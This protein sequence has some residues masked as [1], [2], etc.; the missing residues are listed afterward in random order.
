[1]GKNR[2]VYILF[3]ALGVYLL[4]LYD[5]YV[6]FVVFCLLLF[7]PLLSLLCLLFW[8]LQVK[9]T[10]SI[11]EKV[12]NKNESCEFRL[13]LKNNSIFPILNGMIRIQYRLNPHGTEERKNSSF[14][15]DSREK[16]QIVQKIPCPHCGMVTVSVE[17]IK[18]YDYFRLF[19]VR[20]PVNI[21]ETALIFPV[22]SEQDKQQVEERVQKNIA[23]DVYGE[24]NP[25]VKDI[26]EYRQG[27]SL[28]RI[29]WKLSSKQQQLMVKE[30]SG[31]QYQKER[32]SFSLLYEGET[33]DFE[34]YDRKVE[35]LANTCFSM[36]MQQRP[37]E[38]VWYHP[39][40]Q[41]FETMEIEKMEDIDFLL[42]NVMRAGVAKKAENDEEQL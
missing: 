37:H 33:F 3:L 22:Y 35:E 20:I 13:K 16:K 14:L 6:S 32:I 42:A 12:V 17:K 36:L 24:T 40:R 19:S 5:K 2:V 10:G 21:G 7:V 28:K 30:Y 41:C 11:T 1:M 29:H 25:E 15:L 31:E 23:I 4:V 34:W 9:A 26:R 27:D 39:M 8:K 38:V 18:I